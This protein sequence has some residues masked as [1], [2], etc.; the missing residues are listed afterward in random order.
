MKKEDS[1]KSINSSLQN[2]AEDQPQT[3]G[4]TECSVELSDS[5][6]DNHNEEHENQKHA[7]KTNDLQTQ[8]TLNSERNDDVIVEGVE[9]TNLPHNDENAT[10][11][12][13]TTVSKDEQ[14]ETSNDENGTTDI[15]TDVAIAN[16]CENII[17]HKESSEEIRVN[18]DE[19]L[20][21]VEVNQEVIEPSIATDLPNCNEDATVSQSTSVSNDGKIE[22][23]TDEN[24]TRD[25]N[26]DVALSDKCDNIIK[27]NENSEE[28][29]ENLDEAMEVME[30]DQE[31]T[32]HADSLHKNTS[33]TKSSGDQ[34]KL[35][36]S[37]EIIEI[38]DETDG[39]LKAKKSSEEKCI[40][41]TQG[42]TI[43]KKKLEITP[44]KYLS[45]KQIQKKMESEK[46]RVE[47][48]KE[49][50]EKER[51]RNEERDR[52]MK[53]KQKKKEDKQRELEQKQK[54]KELKEEQ[55]QKE[56][57]LKE[58]QK[59]K[60][61]EEKELKRKEEEQKRKDK[62]MEKQREEEKKQKAAAAFANFFVPKKSDNQ[63]PSEDKKSELHSSI[64]MAFEVKSDMKL[65]PSRRLPLSEKQR[66]IL[67]N[68]LNVQSDSVTYLKDL[69]SG[70]NIG[71]CPKTWP[72]EDVA[73]DDADDDVEI[74]EEE[75]KNVG[76][77]ISEDI[78]PTKVR[79]KFLKFHENR[80]PAYFG[81]WRK[82]SKFIRPRKPLAE[83]TDTFNY[84]EDS[85]DDWEEEEQGESLTGSDDEADKE[86]EDEKD[87][88]EV[89][90][91]FFVPHGHLSDDEVDDEENKRMSPESMKQKLK[92]LKDEFDLDMKSK[93]HKL[94]PKAIGCIWYKKDGGN[95][96]EA[97]HKYLQPLAILCRGNIEIKSRNHIFSLQIKQKKPLNPEVIPLFIKF[98]HGSD[99]RKKHVFQKFKSYMLENGNVLEFS[100]RSLLTYLSENA[101]LKKME[102]GP[103]KNKV[104]WVVHAD[105]LKKY[106]LEIDV[107]NAGSD[108]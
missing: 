96:D 92:L 43:D 53:E 82:K 84:E 22:I 11:I 3:V 13:S 55:K 93:T 51:K 28:S 63:C 74:V 107:L 65:P 78:Q 59:R 27:N 33:P 14:L 24:G 48:Q 23:S 75:T 61:R 58:E 26:K 85:G 6:K 69:K 17:K 19:G 56:K 66:E 12:Q 100:K 45:P 18:L 91:E 76:E 15:N 70:K 60:E 77:N 98:I 25:I 89:D 105:I 29:T 87:D 79:A 2:V 16:K 71:R 72:Y 39:T 21:G 64:F 54:E 62:E 86:N 88:Y 81:T 41:S 83:D 80:R 30:V 67:D 40:P 42:S 37:V 52:I 103:N 57:E 34:N 73:D 7:E 35:D 46:K 9:D 104:N 68:Y 108:N 95:V 1:E 31:V 10:V 94:K 36:E 101:S 97:I 44:K 47:R 90:N 5:V 50:E 8:G 49:K 106:S 32:E 4:A 99:E 38:E 20:D 102:S